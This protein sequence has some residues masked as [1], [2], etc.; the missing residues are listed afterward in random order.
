MTFQGITLFELVCLVVAKESLQLIPL[1][2]LAALFD[3]PRTDHAKTIW[4]K[5]IPF[6]FATKTCWDT[7]ILQ[8]ISKQGGKTNN[9]Y[10]KAKNELCKTQN[11][12][13]SFWG[14]YNAVLLKDI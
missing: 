4:G 12:K 10:F 11:E 6:V 3:Y 2:S 14:T 5:F 7:Q 13:N 1:I 9:F 8:L